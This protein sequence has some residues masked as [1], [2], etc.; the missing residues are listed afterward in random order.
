MAYHQSGPPKSR[1]PQSG[2]K[3][4]LDD[5]GRELL[6]RFKGEWITTA[7]DKACSDHANDFG[8]Y[9]AVHKVTRTQIRNIF[10][11]LR[12]IEARGA[13]KSPEQ[14]RHLHHKL[15]YTKARL[16]EQKLEESV[17]T[18]FQKVLDKGLAAIPDTEDGQEAP[19]SRFVSY[20]EAVL[21]FHRYHGGKEK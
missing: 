18:A 7:F 19:F 4:F 2:S 13:N 11:E 5:E 6:D 16:D 12:R 8:R 3:V 15:C 10:G 21:A 20:F 14:I 9:L 1:G 17:T